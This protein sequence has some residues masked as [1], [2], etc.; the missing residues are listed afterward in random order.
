M[1]KK[2]KKM[3]AKDFELPVE[4]SILP[5]NMTH[6]WIE[7]EE[8]ISKKKQQPNKIKKKLPKKDKSTEQ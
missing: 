6:S 3:D 4:G 2:F 8:H 1:V 7:T 5:P